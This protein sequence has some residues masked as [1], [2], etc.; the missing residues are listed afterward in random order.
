[1]R[2]GAE[3]ARGI[4]RNV[5]RYLLS[6]PEN[7][8]VFLLDL[9]AD[10]LEYAV[11]QHLSVYAPRVAYAV[12][13]LAKVEEVRAAVTKAAEFFD[14][15]IDVLINNAGKLICYALFENGK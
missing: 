4:G 9:N 10:E 8:R 12:V 14:D 7:H 15:R 1:M 5:A 6:R 13:N 3:H 11:T 2:D